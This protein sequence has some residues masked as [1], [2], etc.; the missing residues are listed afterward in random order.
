MTQATPFTVSEVLESHDTQA[1]QAFALAAEAFV[2]LH[3][4][5]PALRIASVSLA[6]GL[7]YE[8]RVLPEAARLNRTLLE[9]QALVL[10]AGHAA[11]ALLAEQNGG[12]ESG[13][14]LPLALNVLER[15]LLPALNDDEATEVASY[16]RALYVRAR[17]LLRAHWSEVSVLAIGVQGTAGTL[18]AHEL[19][20]RLNCVQ[21]IRSSLLN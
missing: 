14:G 7:Q 12:N 16:A 1:V 9:E 20:Q 17:G 8:S 19:R 6:G 5:R 10:A 11:Q 4:A 15:W 3:L 2:V 21:G 18:D 13:A